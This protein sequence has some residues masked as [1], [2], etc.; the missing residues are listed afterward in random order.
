MYKKSLQKVIR[1]RSSP[2]GMNGFRPTQGFRP[3]R[4]LLMYIPNEPNDRPLFVEGTFSPPFS[5][6]R[7]SYRNSRGPIWVLGIIY[8]YIHNHPALK[9]TLQQPKKLASSP[10][11]KEGGGGEIE[12]PSI[13]RNRKSRE[14]SFLCAPHLEFLTNSIHHLHK[15]R[16]QH[17]RSMS[18]EQPP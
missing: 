13:H 7:N 5:K 10:K 8:I 18:L 9:K 17:H 15:H 4:T 14:S 12:Q 16:M 1:P 11:K 3:C 2:H 6:G